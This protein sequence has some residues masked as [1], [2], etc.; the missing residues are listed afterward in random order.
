[1]TNQA[2]A[3]DGLA[4][5]V[6]LLRASTDAG[7]PEVLMLERPDRGSFAGAWVF[8]GGS[9]DLEDYAGSADVSA[10]VR[11]TRDDEALRR[12]AARETLEETGLVL[13]ESDL[14]ALARWHP[15]VQAPKRLLTSFFAAEAP[16]GDVVVSPHEAVGYEWISPSDALERHAAGEMLL[17]PPTWV[18]LHALVGAGGV[19]DVLEAARTRGPQEFAARFGV[20]GKV[21]FWDGDVAY[22]DD[23][24]LDDDGGRHR[25]DMRAR[26][27]TY[28]RTSG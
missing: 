18:T 5:T 8:P 7:A 24:V 1:M 21:V 26:P 3:A 27:W 20:G 4:A 13:A 22:G 28:T 9:V 10:G 11:E 25:L 16:A 6:V 17:Y 12:A 2:P 23:A 19:D 15:P 14:V